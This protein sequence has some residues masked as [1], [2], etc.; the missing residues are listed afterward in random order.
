[1]NISILGSGN[2]GVALASDLSSIY[3]NVTLIKTSRSIHN[4]CYELIKGKNS[5]IFIKESDV[6][7]KTT[8]KEVTDDISKI[9]DSEIVFVTI[10]TTYHED[11]IKRAKDYFGKN[12]IVVFVPSYMSAFY[13]RK[14]IKGDLPTIV[15][16]TGTPVE[17]R[18]EMNILPGKCV[19]R[20]G[21]RLKKNYVCVFQKERTE[22]AIRKLRT[23]G[24][25]FKEKYS[26]IE[27]GLLNPNLILHTSGSI[28][29]IPRIERAKENFCMYHEAFSRENE[30]MMRIIEDMD[31]E[32]NKVLNKL[33]YK[34]VSFIQTADFWGENALEK[35][36]KYA[37][38]SDR[39]NAPSTINSRYIREDVSQGLVLLESIAEHIGIK[40]P[41]VSSLINIASSALPYD[42]RGNG[43]TIEKL[44]AKDYIEKLLK[45]NG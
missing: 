23:T 37:E 25:P 14:Y 13:M 31:I 8:V 5:E 28:M 35:F 22:Y 39:A 27:A 12:Q 17:G 32:K 33:G 21:S 1:M 40:T 19:F 30:A 24:Y 10:Q 16:M 15:E 26:T 45:K 42:F 41:L 18:I 34:S 38:S 3:H 7:T 29:S 9:K 43:R 11:L 6:L 2:V 4:D 20:V 44:E 36:Y